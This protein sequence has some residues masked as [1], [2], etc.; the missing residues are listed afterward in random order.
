[1]GCLLDT[2]FVAIFS[3]IAILLTWNQIRAAVGAII[4]MCVQN[5]IQ[6]SQGGRAYYGPAPRVTSR[7]GSPMQVTGL[8]ALPPHTNVTIFQQQEPWTNMTEELQS[9]TWRAILNRTPLTQCLTA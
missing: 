4:N 1:M 6:T 5:P 9:C 7:D 2:C 8:N 3:E